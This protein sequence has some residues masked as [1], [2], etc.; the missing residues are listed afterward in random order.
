MIVLV[1][2]TR[3]WADSAV[4]RYAESHPHHV[5]RTRPGGPGIAVFSRSPVRPLEGLAVTSPST[6]ALAVHVDDRAGDPDAAWVLVA[7]HPHPPSRRDGWRGRRQTLDDVVRWRARL[8]ARYAVVGDINASPCEADF[9]RF[10][11]KLALTPPADAP[12]TWPVV[13]LLP[14]ML[15]PDHVLAGPGLRVEALHVGPEIGSDHLPLFAT[16]R[17]MPFSP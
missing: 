17:L 14:V 16:L 2:V 4:R 15:A 6:R 1:E 11:A 10:V 5:I 3:A 12:A 8:G 7:L 13:P 9:R